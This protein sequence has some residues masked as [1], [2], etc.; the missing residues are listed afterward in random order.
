MTICFASDAP[1]LP[2]RRIPPPLTKLHH[3]IHHVKPKEV[4]HAVHGP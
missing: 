1:H 4:I 2:E 3:R